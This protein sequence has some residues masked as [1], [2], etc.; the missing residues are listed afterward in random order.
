MPTR[1]ISHAQNA[2]DVVLWRALGEIEE[3]LYIDVGANHPVEDSVTW[4]FYKRA[5]RGLVIDPHPEFAEL[6]REQRPDDIVEQVAISDRPGAITLHA[7]DGTGLSTVLDDVSAEHVASGIEVH[8]IE[9]ST[10]RLSDLIDDHGLSERDIHFLSID[11]EGAEPDVI[12]TV[13]FSRHRPWVL[14]IEATAPNSTRQVHD[15]WEP[16]VLDAGYEFVLFDGLSRFYVA[17]EHAERLR[18]SLSY[19]ACVLDD[20]ID[21]HQDGQIR[22]IAELH[23]ELQEANERLEASSAHI[24]DLQDRWSI[25]TAQLQSSVEGLRERLQDRREDLKKARARLMATRAEL[26]HANDELAAIRSSRSW[27]LTRPLR[28]LRH[29]R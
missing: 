11:T 8:N 16:T 26:R 18:A 29:E 9:V 6:L 24:A 23:D 27:R 20:Y 3:G 7:F 2:E 10:A 13:D 4:A 17:R 25:E 22:R 14:L 15:V 28:R 5:W 19:P 12:A 21:W 1:F